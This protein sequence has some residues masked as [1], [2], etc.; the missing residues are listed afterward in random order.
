M[1][2]MLF[3]NIKKERELLESQK[4]EELYINAI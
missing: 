4:N 1:T 3:K 2:T